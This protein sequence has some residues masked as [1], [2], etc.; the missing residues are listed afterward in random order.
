M[1]DLAAI[2]VGLGTGLLIGLPALVVYRHDIARNFRRLPM[3][4]GVGTAGKTDSESQR[5]REEHGD[6]GD[7]LAPAIAIFGIAAG[8]VTALYGTFSGEIVFL[9][10]GLF[11]ML[12]ILIAW[13]AT[14]A[15]ND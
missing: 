15:V 10:S 14:W 8:A 7:R 5:S 11:V 3:A 9:A 2:L 12:S 6:G 13:L 4:L 1:S